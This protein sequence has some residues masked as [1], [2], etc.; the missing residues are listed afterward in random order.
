MRRWLL[1][2]GLGLLSL[3]A[4]C[5]SEDGADCGDDL[6]TPDATTEPAN[7]TADSGPEDGGKLTWTP[8]DAGRCVQQLVGWI[9]MERLRQLS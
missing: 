2:I 1:G 7:D 3:C 9:A 4:S 6:V 5:T 8:K